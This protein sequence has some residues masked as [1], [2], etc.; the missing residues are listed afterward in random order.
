ME[1]L[2][3][4]LPDLNSGQMDRYRIPWIILSEPTIY[5]GSAQTRFKPKTKKQPVFGF[6]QLS[7]DLLEHDVAEQ[8]NNERSWPDR[9]ALL[10]N[11]A[12]TS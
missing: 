7:S 1:L 9:A 6:G 4:I 3:L 8:V 12:T 10:H 11:T 2:I 5:L